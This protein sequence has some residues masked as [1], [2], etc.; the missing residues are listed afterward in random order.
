MHSRSAVCV[1]FALLMTNTFCSPRTTLFVSHVFCKVYCIACFEFFQPCNAHDPGIAIEV[2]ILH[3]SCSTS[4]E[5]VVLVFMTHDKHVF[6]MA[7][8]LWQPTQAVTLCST[9]T[10]LTPHITA[11]CL[12]GPHCAA[13]SRLATVAMYTWHASPACDGPHASPNPAPR[14][15]H[16][17]PCP[18]PPSMTPP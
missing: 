6:R 2:Q 11:A 10:A 14:T 8:R 1:P 3:V 4:L 16:P 13:C 9:A 5:L 7:G 12:Q 17:L 18:P 15:P